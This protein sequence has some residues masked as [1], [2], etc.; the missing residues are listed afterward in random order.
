[1]TTATTVRPALPEGL[2]R[3][4]RKPGGN[5]IRRKWDIHEH[6]QD[7]VPDSG[8]VILASNHIGWLDGPLIV[9]TSPRPVHALVKAEEFTGAKA[10]FLRAAGQVSIIRNGVDTKAVRSAVGALQNDQGILMF[11]EG[12]RGTGRFSS[13][14]PG[15]GYLSIVTG[16]PIV[17]VAVFGTRHEGEDIDVR[18]EKGRRI[19]VHYGRSFWFA[20]LAPPRRKAD[21]AEAT[22]EVRLRLVRHLEA[23]Q[24][25]TSIALPVTDNGRGP[26]A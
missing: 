10:P 13:L 4:A 22:E 5:H 25:M 9:A 17:P 12:R 1:M 7:Y 19:E 3:F 16:A 20:P 18:P 11:P 15:I 8:P 6:G 24:K 2:L 21:V 14:Y 26:H 23:A